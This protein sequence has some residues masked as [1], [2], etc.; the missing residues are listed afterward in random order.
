MDAQPI[1]FK[2]CLAQAHFN[3]VETYLTI[4]KQLPM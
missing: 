2:A 3:Y 4:K 1:D